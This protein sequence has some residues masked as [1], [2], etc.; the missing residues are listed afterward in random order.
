MIEGYLALL[1]D[2][3]P[4]AGRKAIVLHDVRRTE[5]VQGLADLV[6]GG[7]D[8]RGR[9][10]HSRLGHHFLGEGLAALESSRLGRGTEAID[11][12][13]PNCVRCAVDQWKL[14]PDDDQVAVQSLGEGSDSPR[15]GYVDRECPYDL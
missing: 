12:Q 5:T 6:H 13:C 3:D 11:P 14:R 2:H 4:L 15:I 7:A 10:R 9:R 1:A 8:D